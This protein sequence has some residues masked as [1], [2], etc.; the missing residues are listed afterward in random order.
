[1]SKIAILTSTYNHPKR[2]YELYESLEKQNDTEF[3]WCIIDDGSEI[4]TEKTAEKIQEVASINVQYH[5]I[6]N[7]G[8]SRAIRY[9]LD[10]LKDYAFI[11]IV[12]DDEY[13]NPNAIDIIKEY[14]RKYRESN[15]GV[16][17]FNRSDENGE[18][19]A[20][21]IDEEDKIMSNQKRRRLGY[22]QDGYIGYF[23]DKID[24]I[25][26]PEF[27][28]EKYVGPSVL[29]MLVT[30]QYDM[31]WSTAVLGRTE[32][33]SGGITKQGR[34][35]RVKNPKGM[36]VYCLLMQHDDSGW[37]LKNAYS[38]YGYAYLYYAGLSETDVRKEA[39]AFKQRLNPLAKPLGMIL[40]MH[41]KN[42][43]SGHE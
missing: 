23:V 29:F 18:I 38:V 20:N 35:L 14:E 25:R 40:A 1:M 30:A 43:F 5:R 36:Y 7:G 31:V 10:L 21:K 11:T 3:M 42:K 19:I 33:L 17:H 12:D 16:I 6:N 2:L 13:L 4:T 32:Y 15:C 28:N 41:W 9:G 24:N 34:G 26:S 37:Y 22:F 39:S 8:K 27:D